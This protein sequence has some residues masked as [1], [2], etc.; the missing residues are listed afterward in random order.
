MRKLVGTLIS[1]IC[2]LALIAVLSPLGMSFWVQD[3]YQQ[4][5]DR[6]NRSHSVVIKIKQFDR[7]WFTSYATLEVTLQRHWFVPQ[8]NNLTPTDNQPTSI[9]IHSAS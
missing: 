7:G 6:V 5:V 1:L 3:H 4:I 8:G 2:I 9:D